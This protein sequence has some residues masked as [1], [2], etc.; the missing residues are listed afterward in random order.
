MAT[1]VFGLATAATSLSIRCLQPGWV[2][3]DGLASVLLAQPLPVPDQTVS[4]QPRALPFE[5][6]EV[7][8]TAVTSG[9]AAG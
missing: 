6:S 9:E 3:Q 2:C 1:P 4:P 8:P 7:P 5:V